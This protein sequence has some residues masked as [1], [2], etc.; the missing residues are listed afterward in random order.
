MVISKAFFIVAGIVIAA[1]ILYKSFLG[2]GKLEREY[3][4]QY[5]KI[6]TSD[7][8]KVKGQYEK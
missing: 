4:V 7:E 2:T 5:N 3:D 8:Y 1:Y 6:L